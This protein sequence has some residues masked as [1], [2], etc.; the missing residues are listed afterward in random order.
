MI[1]HTDVTMGSAPSDILN[2]SIDN[3]IHSEESFTSTE[4]CN[5]A[6]GCPVQSESTGTSNAVN[7]VWHMNVTYECDMYFLSPCLCIHIP[8]NEICSVE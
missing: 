4:K 7:D 5:A 8:N 2:T 3:P 1:G 6:T